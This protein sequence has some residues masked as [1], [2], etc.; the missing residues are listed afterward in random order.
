[1]LE[2][3]EPEPQNKPIPTVV[4]PLFQAASSDALQG[5]QARLAILPF[6][7]SELGLK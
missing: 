5:Y 3:W 7:T 4:C 1:M 6:L 2:P